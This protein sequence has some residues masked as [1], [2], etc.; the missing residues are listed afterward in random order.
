VIPRKR[1]SQAWTVAC[2][3]AGSDASKSSLPCVACNRVQTRPLQ[4]SVEN[5]EWSVYWAVQVMRA[6]QWPS[7][8][9]ENWRT[10]TVKRCDTCPQA[11]PP[12]HVDVAVRAELE[13]AVWAEKIRAISNRKSR[14][15]YRWAK[16]ALQRV[17]WFWA[18]FLLLGKQR[19]RTPKAR[20]ENKLSDFRSKK[21][22]RFQLEI[23]EN[24]Y[25]LDLPKAEHWGWTYSICDPPQAEFPECIH[26]FVPPSQKKCGSTT[27]SMDPLPQKNMRPPTL[28]KI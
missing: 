14:N 15:M 10:T 2:W 16:R 3:R 8:N 27:Q 21:F 25:V 13:Y 20:A 23:P 19:L 28:S 11:A 18:R 1:K 24:C 5:K 4:R 22:P 9:E 12:H 6:P 26:S 7:E 17:S